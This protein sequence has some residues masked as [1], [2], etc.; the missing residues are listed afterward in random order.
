MIVKL[1]LGRQRNPRLCALHDLQ[2][3][4]STSIC[5]ALDRGSV[6]FSTEDVHPSLQFQQKPRFPRF[7]CL[8]SHFRHVHYI[9]LLRV[10]M[11]DF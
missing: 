5:H 4:I 9:T 3:V 6:M 1:G 7:W 10:A 8:L 2:T 11:H